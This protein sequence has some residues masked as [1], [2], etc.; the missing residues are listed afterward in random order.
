MT[1]PLVLSLVAVM[2]AFLRLHVLYLTLQDAA[3][4]VA[5]KLVLA[6]AAGVDPLSGAARADASDTVV[7]LCAAKQIRDPHRCSVTI[8][9]DGE[10]ITVRVTYPSALSY[11]SPRLDRVTR[12][13]PVTA[14]STH[15]KLY[16]SQ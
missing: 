14:A 15:R 2:L 8:E 6:E 3:S 10:H 11:L 13:T 12:Q 9:D 4:A 7:A 5:R 1:V 16:L